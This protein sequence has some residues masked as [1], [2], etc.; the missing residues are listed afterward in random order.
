MESPLAKLNLAKREISEIRRFFAFFS[1][2]SISIYRSVS[3]SIML[4]GASPV[5]DSKTLDN[6]FSVI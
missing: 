5:K 6:R 1:Y 4:S 3:S 2:R